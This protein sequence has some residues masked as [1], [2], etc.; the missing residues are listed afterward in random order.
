MS[1]NKHSRD[2]DIS[3]DELP[4][5]DEE[6]KKELKDGCRCGH[7]Y[8]EDD[9]G[10]PKKRVQ[11]GT[12][13]VHEDSLRTIERFD[14][15]RCSYC[16]RYYELDM[17]IPENYDS[18]CLH[19]YFWINYS[20][21]NRKKVDVGKMKVVDYI[22]KCRSDHNMEQCQRNT[23]SGG[24]FLCEHLIGMKIEGIK[25]HELLMDED[26]KAKSKE[27]YTPDFTIDI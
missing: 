26:K 16:A 4:E 6:E 2:S 13:G 23:P 22:L 18:I 19:C 15:H 21:E 7:C 8:V 5:L 14:A 3:D 12:D 1:N 10:K 20:M 9:L 24:C 25:N 17:I 27:Q 11:L